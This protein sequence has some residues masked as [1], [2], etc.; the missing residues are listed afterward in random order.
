MP[1]L[2]SE[3]KPQSDQEAFQ[4]ELLTGHPR[5]DGSWKTDRQLRM[6]YIQLTDGLISKMVDGVGVVNPETGEQEVRVPDVVVWLDKSARPVSWL[7]RELWSTLAVDPKTG[8]VPKMPDF[9]YVNIDREQWVNMVDPEG[10]GMVDMSRIDPSIIRSLRSIFVPLGAKK[11]GLTAEID[12]APSELDNKTIMLVDEV[13]ASGRTLQYATEFF[14]RAFPT[15][16]IGARHWMRGVTMK[17]NAK[18]NADLP[19]WYNRKSMLGRGIGNRN[20]SLS[21]NS[22]NTTQR[23]GR[24]FLST[25]LREPDPSS[26]RLREELH[27]LATHPD[28][29]VLPSL[30]RQDRDDRNS[31]Y[32]LYNHGATRQEVIQKKNEIKSER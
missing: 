32:S 12:G 27:E 21:G 8:E 26:R 9:K 4:Y 10:A 29:P 30:E 6:E 15:A 17:G 5:T 31:R 18:G 22:E 25:R 13:Y 7:T 14:R 16:Y 24:Y 1:E 2:A 28:V 3:N 19:V 23:L 20:D 11:E